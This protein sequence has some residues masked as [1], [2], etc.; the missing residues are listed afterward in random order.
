M[1]PQGVAGAAAGSDAPGAWTASAARLVQLFGLQID[2]D[3]SD[4]HGEALPRSVDDAALEPVGAALGMGR[5]D[6]LVGA[7]G[8]ERVLHRLQRLRIAHLAAGLEAGVGEPLQ[9]AL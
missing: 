8:A 2:H 4:G 7:E 9:A 6:D 3:V 1:C 5:D